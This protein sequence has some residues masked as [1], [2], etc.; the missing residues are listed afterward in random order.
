MVLNSFKTETFYFIYIY[1]FKWAKAH[2]AL[3]LKFPLFSKTK[4][5]IW[6]YFSNLHCFLKPKIKSEFIF[7]ISIVFLNQKLDLKLFF[8]TPLFSKTKN[9]IWIYFSNLHCF[10]KP[11]IRSK[12]ISHIPLFS[13]TENHIRIYFSR[14]KWAFALI[15][16]KYLAQCPYFETI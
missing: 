15:V 13:K 16:L 12:I 6:I 7:W 5:L 4:N 9:Q 14:R 8:K 1:I 10:P 2:F 11:K 3:F